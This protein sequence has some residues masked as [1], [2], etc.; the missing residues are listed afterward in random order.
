MV[1]GFTKQITMLPY[2]ESQAV[3]DTQAPVINNMF[4]NDAESFSNGAVISPDAL[5]YINVTDNEGIN[6]QSSS[7]ELNMDLVLDGGRST[8]SDVSCYTMVDGDG[9]AI[10]IEYPLSNLTEGMHTLTYTVYDV[11]GNSAT[12]TIS[13]MVGQTSTSTL[14][15]D[16]WPAYNDGEVNFGLETTLSQSPEFTVR[17]IDATGNL[18]WKTTAS[19]FPVSWNMRDLQGKKVPA[20]LYRYYGTYNNGADYGGTSINKLIVLDAVKSA[21]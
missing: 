13:F 8:Y 12:R 20:G 21:H 18:V 3:N 10:N 15:A 7:L 17:V 14:T 9:R 16:K 5:L 4:I 1:N 2:D 11:V 19:S 6:L